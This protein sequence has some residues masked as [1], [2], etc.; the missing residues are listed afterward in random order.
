MPEGERP[1]EPEWVETSGSPEARPPR[2]YFQELF[3]WLYGFGQLLFAVVQMFHP[4]HHQSSLFSINSFW[5]EDC[6]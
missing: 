1:R 2:M 6:F 4:I 5:L 3:L